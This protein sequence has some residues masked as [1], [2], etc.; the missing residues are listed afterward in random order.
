MKKPTPKPTPTTAGPPPE[1]MRPKPRPVSPEKGSSAPMTSQR[2]KPNPKAPSK[3]VPMGTA[4][5][6]S[7]RVVAKANASSV[8]PTKSKKPVQRPDTSYRG[9]T[10][11]LA[12]DIVSAIGKGLSGSPKPKKRKT[13][14][15]V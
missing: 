8:A 14:W 3:K 5:G 15:N 13:G 2:P 1:K 9:Y 10:T 11:K 6:S 4:E 12:K 7:G